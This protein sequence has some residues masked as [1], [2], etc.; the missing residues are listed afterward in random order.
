[1]FNYLI[2]YLINYLF[3]TLFLV[4]FFYII[5]ICLYHY[6]PAPRFHAASAARKRGD[7]RQ[8][9]SAAAAHEGAEWRGETSCAACGVPRPNVW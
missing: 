8:N 5:Y 1:M 4:S 6:W 2:I 9:A 7:V 3:F